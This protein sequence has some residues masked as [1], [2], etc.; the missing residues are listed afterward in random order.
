MSSATTTQPQTAESA[1]ASQVAVIAG[2][3]IGAIGAAAFFSSIPLL[4]DLSNRETLL[5][6]L[7][8]T[9][10]IMM[11]VGFS[12]VAL[13]LPSFATHLRLPRWAILTSAAGCVALAA[14]AWAMGT[15]APALAHMLTDAQWDQGPGV[16]GTL[17]FLPKGLL[18][19]VGFT[20][21]AITGWRRKVASR[22]ACALLALAALIALVT[23]PLPQMPTALLGGL[24]L[25]WF[26][27]SAHPTPEPNTP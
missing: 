15:I 27:R 10:N 13:A 7:T 1:P 16:L 4:N 18:C 20:A 3:L 17:A 8:I 9:T 6:P 25:A 26:A 23:S 21:M 19:A 5:Q 14:V 2:A 11:A 24:A 12:I 22:G